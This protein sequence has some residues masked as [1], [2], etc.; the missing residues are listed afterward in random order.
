MLD[1]YLE[2]IGIYRERNGR[3]LWIAPSLVH[4]TREQVV[5]LILQ[6]PIIGDGRWPLPPSGNYIDPLCGTTAIKTHAYYEIACWYGGEITTRLDRCG[7]DGVTLQDEIALDLWETF[8]ETAESALRYITGKR[9]KTTPY[10][11]WKAS[12]NY[13]MGITK[14]G[15]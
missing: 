2:R 6:L 5:W 4:F 13:Y 1:Y 15:T 7:K 11:Q 8:S 14:R 3:L 12:R 10:F 9:R